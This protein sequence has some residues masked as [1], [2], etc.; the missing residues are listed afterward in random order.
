V[1]QT[2]TD[3]SSL[4]L[5]MLMA[6][7]RP[8]SVVKCTRP[9]SSEAALKIVAQGCGVKLQ[10]AEPVGLSFQMAVSVVR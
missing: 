8:S 9:S 10:R 1:L 7:M 2:F 5:S 3:Q 6:Q 4:P